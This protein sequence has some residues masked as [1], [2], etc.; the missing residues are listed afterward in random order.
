MYFAENKKVGLYAVHKPLLT[1]SALIS[2]EKASLQTTTLGSCILS[3]GCFYPF[4]IGPDRL[5][6]E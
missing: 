6:L 4:P 5:I 3:N 2:G 1:K